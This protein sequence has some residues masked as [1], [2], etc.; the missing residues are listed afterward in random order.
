MQT[1]QLGGR[2]KMPV[3][4]PLHLARAF[5]RWQRSLGKSTALVFLDLTEAFYRVICP[6][7]LGGDLTDEQIAF[8]ASR[9]NL[10]DDAWCTP[11]LP[12]PATSLKQE[13]ALAS[14]ASCSCPPGH[15]VQGW[16]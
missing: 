8:L 12:N 10:Q 6:L 11:S 7:A 15:M 5:L 9:L 2:A 4:V 13:Q 1:Q 16:Q 14:S 3:G